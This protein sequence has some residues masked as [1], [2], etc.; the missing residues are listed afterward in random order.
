MNLKNRNNAIGPQIREKKQKSRL[1]AVLAAGSVLGALSASTQHFAASFRYDPI[2]G[3]HYNG[4]YWPW[5]I[6]VWAGRW[7]TE[8]P[9]PFMRSGSIGIMVAGIG[10]TGILITKMIQAN[11]AKAKPLFARFSPLGR[12][13]RHYDS[14]IVGRQRCIC[15]W[16]AR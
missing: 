5:E 11:S 2:L 14:G 10:L 15:W 6:L 3:S 12:Q 1:H 16:L 4:I 13:K 8:Q 9:E 7:Y